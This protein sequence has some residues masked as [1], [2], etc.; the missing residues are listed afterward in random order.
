MKITLYSANIRRYDRP[1]NLPGVVVFNG[2]KDFA[3]PRKESRKYKILSNLYLDCD[4]SIYMDANIAPVWHPK[5]MVE[6]LLGTADMAVHR[7]P[8]R[9]CLYAEAA[10]VIALRKD[11]ASTVNQQVS[12]YEKQGYPQNNGLY[13]CG[14]IIRRHNER[15]R[16]FNNEWFAQVT[17]F[18][19]RDQISF[20][21]ALAIS[22]GIDLNIIEGDLRRQPFIK[23]HKHK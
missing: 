15:I 5:R 20:P 12:H 18:S 23:Y 16:R 1:L 17:R 10:K 4:V 6:E 7:H 8:V 3:D 14:F 9:K 21:Y 22:P 13:E 2:H 11:I 19:T